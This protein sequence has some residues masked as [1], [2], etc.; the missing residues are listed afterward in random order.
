MVNSSSTPE[1]HT[2]MTSTFTPSTYDKTQPPQEHAECEADN[3]SYH[4]AQG[5]DSKKDVTVL[6]SSMSELKPS[7]NYIEAV[8]AVTLAGDNK[9]KVATDANEEDDNGQEYLQGVQLWLVY[10]SMLLCIFLVSLDFTIL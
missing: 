9:E 10:L 7:P 3:Q 6:G 2:S 4:S 1:E 5:E 8:D